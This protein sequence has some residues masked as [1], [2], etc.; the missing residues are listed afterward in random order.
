MK[1]SKIPRTA[2]LV[3]LGYLL[4]DMQSNPRNRLLLVARSVGGICLVSQTSTAFSE[5]A[6]CLWV[7]LVLESPTNNKN[8]CVFHLERFKALCE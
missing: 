1:P 5:Q 4:S 6:P 8:K 7:E 3:L 2:T